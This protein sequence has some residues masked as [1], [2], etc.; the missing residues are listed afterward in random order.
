MVGAL[1][2]GDKLAAKLAELSALVTK[3]A[4][5]RVGFLEG[6]TYSDGTSVPM[7]AAIQEYGAPKAGIPPRPYFRTMIA[8]ES[9]NWGNAIERGLKATGFDSEKTLTVMGDHIKGQ[10]QQSIKDVQSPALSPVTL[11]LRER[12]GNQPHEITFADVQR[13]RHD[14][15]MG[16][17]PN[18]TATQSKPLIWTGHL[19][20][21]VD[22]E[23]K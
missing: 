22:Y 1:S 4:S 12:F 8:K 18:V 23:V 19:W 5:V 6:A 15:A 13:A 11:L 14:V 3:K 7:V 9:G 20:N 10:L 21:S 16:T 2:G 17:V